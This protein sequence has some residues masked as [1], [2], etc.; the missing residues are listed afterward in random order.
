MRE[1][2]TIVPCSEQRWRWLGASVRLV[3]FEKAEKTLCKRLSGAGSVSFQVALCR[4]HFLN[5]ELM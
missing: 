3:R 2:L 5:R 4:P 1:H